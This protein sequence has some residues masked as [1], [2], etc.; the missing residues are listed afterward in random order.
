M[1]Y[2]V[3]HWGTTSDNRLRYWLVGSGLIWLLLPTQLADVMFSSELYAPN[4]V[5]DSAG[6][7]IMGL[8]VSLLP[9]AVLAT[10][11]SAAVVFA[12]V[13]KRES[14]VPVLSAR[15]GSNLKNLAVTTVIAIPV[16]PLLFDVA[17]YLWEI[18]VPQ[19]VSSDCNGTADLVT[20]NV[21]RSLFQTSPFIE[22]MLVLWFLHIRALLLSRRIA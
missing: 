6:P 19:T 15:L 18:V 22:L 11:F 16:L 4:I 3:K 14:G 13:R 5:C 9:W 20:V 8:M 17:L 1:R 7:L 12:I 10:G 2:H 21:R